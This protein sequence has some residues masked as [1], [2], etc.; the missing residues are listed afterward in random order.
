MVNQEKPQRGDMAMRTLVT[1][2]QMTQGV[3]T[4]KELGCWG[5]RVML[6]V[7]V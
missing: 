2:G 7:K 4:T 5:V 6:N 3:L 1:N